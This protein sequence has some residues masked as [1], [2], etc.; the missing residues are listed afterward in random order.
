V[1][2]QDTGPP[3]DVSYA[4]FVRSTWSHHLRV[5]RLLTGDQDQAEEL[6]QDC[7]VR[8]Y[9]RWRRV[10]GSGDPRAYLRRMLVNARV[11][12]WRR[13]RREELVWDTPD[14]EDPRSAPHEPHDH[15]RRALLALPRQQRAVV[16]LRHYADLTEP[17]VAAALG[18]SVGTVKSHHAR[19]VTRLRALL[20]HHE[21]EKALR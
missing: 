4:A 12:R 7:L 6:L 15:V 21:P 11:S 3:T 13:F 20:H 5:A 18:C 17:E 1:S 16:V 10:A 8:L 19:A 9:A 2:D 14:L